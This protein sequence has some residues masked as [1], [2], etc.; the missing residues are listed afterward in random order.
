VMT[1]LD[2]LWGSILDE[3]SIDVVQQTASLAIRVPSA[4]G[5]DTHHR[6]EFLGLTDVRFHNEIPSPWEYAELTEI[7]SRRTP[8]GRLMAELLLWS[9]EA[10]LVFEA[11]TAVLD[12]GTL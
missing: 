1:A 6:L 2:A 11:D 5:P 4:S 8:E 10:T 12:G 9:E 3:V 7:R